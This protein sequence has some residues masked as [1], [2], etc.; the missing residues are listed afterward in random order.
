MYLG[1]AFVLGGIPGPILGGYLTDFLVRQNPRWRAW[2]PAL[3]TLLC[4]PIFFACLM[5]TS[6]WAFLGLFSC[7]YL[8]YLIAQPPTISL[9]QLSGKPDERAMAVAVAMLFNNLVGQALGGFLIGLAS[10]NLASSMG[11]HAL[12]S[13]VIGVSA[14]FA[15]P[16]VLLYIWCGRLIG[17]LPEFAPSPSK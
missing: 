6:F 10:T 15:G 12:G 14:A 4:L 5:S 7:G 11:S 1:L 17:E 2:L 9:L 3:A 8:V 16:A 13:A